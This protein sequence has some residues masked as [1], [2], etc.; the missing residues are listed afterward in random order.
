MTLRTKL[1]AKGQVVLPKA[2][3]DALAWQPGQAIEVVQHGGGVTLRAAPTTKGASTEAVLARIW[4][5]NP[6]G[7]PTVTIEDM[8][9]AVRTA[10]ARRAE[11]SR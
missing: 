10:A 9:V 5:R 8:D 6:Y 1:S 2:V 11:R 4:A 7:G 3:R